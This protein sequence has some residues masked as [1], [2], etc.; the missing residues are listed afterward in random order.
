M[1]LHLHFILV[2]SEFNQGIANDLH[3][4]LETED[5]I[6]H[7]WE[8]ELQVS[9]PVKDFKI[10]NNAIYKLAG[11]YPD[12]TTFS[13]NIW[14]MTIIECVTE[15]GNQMQFAVSKKLLKKTEKVVDEKTK[16]THLYFYLRDKLP[17]ENPMNG[18]YILKTY[19]PKELKT[20][21]SKS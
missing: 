16:D 11:Y 8:D 1:N 3:E 6:K 21:R 20:A 10:K 4:G 5:N 2:N 15:S 9:E 12:D 17:L 13:F 18:I 14:D 19:F 7:L